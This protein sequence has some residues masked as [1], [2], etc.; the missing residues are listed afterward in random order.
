MGIIIG[1][2]CGLP[3]GPIR[4]ESCLNF[5]SNKDIGWKN[6]KIRHLSVLTLK[7]VKRQSV[8]F[9]IEVSI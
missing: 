2:D 9:G 8:E 4:F 3:N 7:M 1:S 6:V 5:L